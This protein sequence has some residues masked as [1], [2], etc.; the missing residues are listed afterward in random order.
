MEREGLGGACG[1][2]AILLAQPVPEGRGCARLSA[3]TGNGSPVRQRAP[4]GSRARRAT[5]ATNAAQLGGQ[6]AS[7]YQ[8]ANQPIANATNAQLLNGLPASGYLRPVGNLVVLIAPAGGVWQDAELTVLGDHGIASITGAATRNF[9]V[10]LPLPAPSSLFGVSFRLAAVETCYRVGNAATFITA[11]TTFFVEDNNV[12]QGT[13]NT[14]DR[15]STT[16]ECYTITETELVAFE[17]GPAIRFI[18]T[19][20]NTG[21]FIELT[22]VTATFAPLP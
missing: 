17:G 22:R 6:P 7:A 9:E 10:V 5:T 21:H 20:A 2:P 14:D 12:H 1:T 18:L 8:L 3:F 16:H 11:T 19:F 4:R 15:K 13:H